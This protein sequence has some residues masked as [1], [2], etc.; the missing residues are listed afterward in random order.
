MSDNILSVRI[1]DLIEAGLLSPPAKLHGY[2]GQHRIVAKLKS[3]GSF[4]CGSTTSA[5]PSVAAGQAIT[6]SSGQR[7]PGRGY[8]SVNGWQFW[9]VTD[10]NSAGKTL[11]DL[12]RELLEAQERKPGRN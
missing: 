8:W 5:S 11:A 6:A 12:R 10:G 1:R 9:R 4:V 7:S 2:H 3:D